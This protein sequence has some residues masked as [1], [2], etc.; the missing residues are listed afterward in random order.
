MPGPGSDGPIASRSSDVSSHDVK[1]LERRVVG[2]RHALRRHHAAAEL[3]HHLLPGF[4]AVRDP[5]QIDLVELE[6]A[7]PGPLVVAG[8]AVRVEKGAVR[9]EISGEQAQQAGP[10]ELLAAVAERRAH[11]GFRRQ[12]RQAH[13]QQHTH[14]AHSTSEGG[15]LE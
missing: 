3:P 10:W 1:R 13:A 2:P 14:L 9:R 12:Q 6:P 4:G 11:A 15:L 7:N 8:D 5:C